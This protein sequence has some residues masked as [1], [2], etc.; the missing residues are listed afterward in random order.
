[1]EQARGA[2]HGSGHQ[3]DHFIGVDAAAGRRVPV[4][5]EARHHVALHR[6]DLDD[7]DSGS[8]VAEVGQEP[9]AHGPTG[10]DGAPVLAS[11][12]QFGEDPVGIILLV[13]EG[14][15]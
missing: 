15:R 4:V 7:R 1:M 5:H 14:E 12:E 6:V 10:D 11:L 9:P 8:I 3:V 13:A 2:G